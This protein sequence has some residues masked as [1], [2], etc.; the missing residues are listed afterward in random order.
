MRAA[1]T[2]TWGETAWSEFAPAN[3]LAA[4]LANQCPA[5]SSPIDL[6][7]LMYAALV[8]LALTLV[9]NVIGEWVIHRTSLG[10]SQARGAVK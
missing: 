9:V 8:L 6:G 5:A 4:L 7:V 2:N 3:T 10:T 1:S